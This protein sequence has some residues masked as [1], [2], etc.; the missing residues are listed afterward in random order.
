MAC[1]GMP[2]PPPEGMMTDGDDDGVEGPH[3]RGGAS[4]ESPRVH[5][6]QGLGRIPGHGRWTGAA[7]SAGDTALRSR[8]H[9]R[10]LA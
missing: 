8:G 9:S 4:G 3:R 10:E 7:A 6:A 5:S 1:H 2:Q